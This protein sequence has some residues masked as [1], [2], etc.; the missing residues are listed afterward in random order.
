MLNISHKY[1]NVVII[2]ETFKNLCLPL[3]NS[4]NTICTE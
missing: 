4:Y 2:Y 1:K 3:C